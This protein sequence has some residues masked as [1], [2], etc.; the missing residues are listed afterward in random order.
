MILGSFTKG[1]L[2]S[3]RQF[4]ELRQILCSPIIVISIAYDWCPSCL[5]IGEGIGNAKNRIIGSHPERKA[6][7]ASGE[8]APPPHRWTRRSHS[9]DRE[10]L[11]DSR[12]GTISGRPADR[13]LSVPGAYRLRKDSHRRGYGRVPAEEFRSSNQDRLRGISTQS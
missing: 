1:S 11:P 13:K 7:R 5:S 9:P 8:Q 4:G 12:G 6:G 10:G 3:I 2:Y